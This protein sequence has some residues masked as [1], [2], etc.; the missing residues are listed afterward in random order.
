MIYAPTAI[1]LSRLDAPQAIETI[2][3]EALYADYRA[4]FA[5]A[6]DALRIRYPDLPV[7]DTVLLETEPAAVVGQVF[8]S[9]RRNDRQRVNDGLRALL[10]P[11]ASQSDLAVL[12]AS[13]NI[14]RL[15]IVPASSTA[16]AIMESDT[17]LLRRFLLSFDEPCAGSAG[18]YLFDAWSA[19]PQNE[20]RTLGLWDA[21]VNGWAIHGRRGD[22][23][24]VVVGPF[25][26]APT[27]EEL[28]A[29]R[30]SVAHPNRA[31]E[32]VAISVLAATRVEYEVRLH[33][34]V[35]GNG[36]SPAVVKAEA[37]A[38][39]NKAATD[40]ILIGGEIP[41]GLLP[42]VAYGDGIIK[43][44]DLDPVTIAPDPYKVPVMTGLT[45][46]VEVR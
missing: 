7:H 39:V 35:P 34:E 25:G 46:T 19:W 21:R 13:R 14:E 26:R 45:V 16:A 10:A 36:P 4:R 11:L 28:S 29:V 31:P 41:A 38:R 42:G 20:D 9:S 24:L 6:W 43:V 40:R 2:S 12:V 30:A 27:T 23:D 5:A 17:S 32:A 3:A 33:L 8:S 22:S 44:T 18:R 37:E 1:D 15:T